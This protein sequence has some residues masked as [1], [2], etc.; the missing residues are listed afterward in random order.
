MHEIPASGAEKGGQIP[1]PAAPQETIPSA[2]AEQI[3]RSPP[4]P[5]GAGPYGS[6][7]LGD[8]WTPPAAA[9][10]PPARKSFG[11]KTVLAILL[12]FVLVAGIAW[13]S[14]WL[15]SWKQ[16]TVAPPPAKGSPITL[17]LT[18]DEKLVHQEKLKLEYANE[19]ER[20]D[21]GGGE[22]RFWYLFANTSGAPAELGLLTKNC[23]CSGLECC[24]LTPDEVQVFKTR[25]FRAPQDWPAARAALI[26]AAT[27]IAT[28]RWHQLMLGEGQSMEIPADTM[29]L[30][31]LSF[32]KARLD[33]ERLRLKAQVWVQPVGAPQKDR[34]YLPLEPLVAL[35]PVVR[36]QPDKLDFG[37]L[38]PKGKVT[39]SFLFWSSTRDKVEVALRGAPDECLT[40]KA[41]PLS[42]DK[43]L[44][45]AGNLLKMGIATRVRAACALRVTLWE[46]RGNKQLDMGTVIRPIPVVVK[47]DG[48]VVEAPLTPL[49]IVRVR[50]DI[51]VL[52]A[53]DLGKINLGTFKAQD[54]T[55]QTVVLQAEPNVKLEHEAKLKSPYLE[56]KLGKAKVGENVATWEMEVTALADRLQGELP[57]DTAVVLR[58]TSPDG[59]SRLV[60]IA[61]TG[62]AARD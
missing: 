9:A 19:F 51:K 43:C 61:V 50:S 37:E 58:A 60:R 26:A 44:V 14:Q 54:G 46:Q 25:D 55:T 16:G 35:V 56:V 48:Q 38:L 40:W 15:P 47:A 4:G 33:D 57:Q 36:V 17:L 3:Q 10:P 59:T 28:E 42:P 45:V 7:L 41:E 62:I 21:Q 1:P 31:Q 32:K 5:R 8:D 13:M 39:K 22:G 2:P 34:V 30:L 24:L 29:G 27:R 49:I 52:G 53:D 11:T 18:T 20:N 23:T 12:F 6:R